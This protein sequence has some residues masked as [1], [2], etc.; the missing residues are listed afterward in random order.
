MLRWSSGASL[1]QP[2]R[3]AP[4]QQDHLLL[5]VSTEG[6]QGPLSVGVRLHGRSGWRRVQDV[7]QVQMQVVSP[8]VLRPGHVSL[9]RL[10][11]GQK[12][13]V[14]VELW[15]M[16]EVVR[17]VQ[18]RVEHE[19]LRVVHLRWHR[20]AATEPV[21]E[22]L[23]GAKEVRRGEL[24]LE[25]DADAADPET[26]T[27]VVLRGAAKVRLPQIPVYLRVVRPWRAYPPRVYVSKDRLP[28]H[29]V[30]LVRFEH[31]QGTEAISVSSPPEVRARVVP[32]D[33]TT[34]RVE[35]HV[36]QA[37]SKPAVVKLGG[38]TAGAQVIPLE[39]VPET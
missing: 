39:L 1:R 28:L 23:H 35:L 31:P 13:R 18:A 38:R 33:E 5:A 20:P 21:P 19:A 30:V 9:P 15:G 7:L 8:L 32:L 2:R 36:E 34:W 14:Q 11:P 37:L 16:A 10:R 22:P 6:R 17:N 26:T 3:L 27:R 25:I 4:G 24:L 29:R 12:R